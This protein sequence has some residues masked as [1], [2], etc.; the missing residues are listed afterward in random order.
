ME[1]ASKLIDAV[2]V[3][4]V[5]YC[6]AR[7]GRRAGSYETADA[8]AMNSCREILAGA[9]AATTLLTF[10]YNVTRDLVDDFHR[11]AAELPNPLSVL[12]GQQR[13]IMVLRSLVGLSTD[14]TALA[15]G[16]SV[17]AVRLGQHRALT[18]LRPTPA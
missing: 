10:A 8:V 5:R 9:A 4:V 12:P 6:R 13:E 18:T 11:T 15:L 3:L 7:I 16:C 14:D 2:R 1:T 17:Q